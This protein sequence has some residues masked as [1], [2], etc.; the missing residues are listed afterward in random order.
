[1]FI[2]TS[3]PVNSMARQIREEGGGS[4]PEGETKQLEGEMEG[5]RHKEFLS[6]VS[7]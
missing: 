3:I 1:V 2:I 4:A 7:T 6:V 5:G